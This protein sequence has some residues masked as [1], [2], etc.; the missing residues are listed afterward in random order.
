MDAYS[1]PSV[2]RVVSMFAA[3]MS[4][5]EAAICNVVGYFMHQDPSPIL[6][7][8]PREHDAKQFSKNRL[9][10]MIRDS[11]ALRDSVQ[12]PKTRDSNNTILEKSYPGGR[13][14]LAGSNSPQNL[15]GNPCRIVL[16]DET[17]RMTAS[18]GTEG[19]PIE[20]GEARTATF[21]NRKIGMASTPTERDTS[22]IEK[23]YNDSDRRQYWVPCHACGEFQIL[24]WSQ[25]RWE[26]DEKNHHR[27]ETAKY[28]C[29]E[30]DEP[31]T[32]AQRHNAVRRGEWRAQDEF[33]GTAGFHLNAL[34]SPWSNLSL[35]NLADKW[36]KA[37]GK[38]LL[39]RTFLNTV[40]AETWAEKYEAVD[41]T[42]LLSR[43]E[44]YPM[45]GAQMLIPKEVT[46]LVAGVDTQ[47]DRLEFALHGYGA[48][49]ECWHLEYTVLPGDPGTKDLWDQLWEVISEPRYSEL[50]EEMFVRATSVDT[51]GHFTQQA[52]AF[53]GPRFRYLADNGDRCFVFAIKGQTG[54]GDIWPKR[55]SRKNI[56]KI[57]LFPIRVAPAKE[58]IYSRLNKVRDPGPGFIHFSDQFNDD[59]YKQLTAERVLTKW[60]A[61]GFPSRVW[62]LKVKGNRNEV[63]DLSV[64]AYASLC[65]LESMGFALDRESE[66]RRVEIEEQGHPPGLEDGGQPS[67]SVAP[68][69]AA[70]APP[71]P[72][73]AVG[74]RGG[75]RR[76]VSRSGY[77]GR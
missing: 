14:I 51:G 8:Q 62:E 40:L 36:L 15:A 60:D 52:Y 43:A 29:C 77:L 53:C 3:Q 66:K 61:R 41:S 10:P 13:L 30:C 38:P 5:S 33:T 55:P 59:Y 65:G 57:P 17:D 28:F 69:P 54:N 48:G 9:A 23:A 19:D 35:G 31:W 46:V 72:G 34:Y 75:L 4:K 73:A 70:T 26:K 32:E 2:V 18:S 42:G 16:F 1:D 76:G 63:F 68:S 11:P 50:G 25:V 44:A 24:I 27:P 71:S 58:V 74:G 64:Y 22:R 67:D 56:G 21:G 20:L 37:Q 39:L 6:V 7:V 47:D 45:D 49:E 12:A